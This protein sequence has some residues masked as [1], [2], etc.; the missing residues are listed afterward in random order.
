[1][2]ETL[3]A[4]IR[5][6]GILYILLVIAITMREFGRA[7][8][9]DKLGSVVP[10]MEGRITLNPLAHMDLMGTVILPIVCLSLCVGTQFPLV[11]GWGKPVNAPFTNPKTY[12]RD[13]VITTLAGAAM[14]LAIAFA[15][16]VLL[17]VFAAFRLEAY[18]TV[19]T[20]AISIN[21]VIFVINMLP[22]PPLDG[23]RLLKYAIKMSEETYMRLSS[24]GIAIFFIIIFFPPTKQIFLSLVNIVYIAFIKIAD[25][26]FKLFFS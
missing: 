5:M 13:D 17:A 15:A 1:M 16:A 8:A 19:A 14:N 23:G 26:I 9:A 20:Y 10:R 25:I 18:E 24:W 11:F 4:Q 3:I 12:I 21:A 2:S 7:Y 6:G 22:V